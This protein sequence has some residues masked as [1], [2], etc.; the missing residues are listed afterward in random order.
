MVLTVGTPPGSLRI[1]IKS[2]LGRRALFLTHRRSNCCPIP[3]C[4]RAWLFWIGR[5]RQASQNELAIPKTIFADCF[6]LWLR[7]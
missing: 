3:V 7:G 1:G 6:S 2:A 5:P 4:P